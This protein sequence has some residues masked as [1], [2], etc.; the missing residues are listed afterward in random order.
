V[1]RNYRMG[2]E[3]RRKETKIYFLFMDYLRMLPV[4]H[5]MQH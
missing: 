3:F 1:E 5:T 4:T 2:K